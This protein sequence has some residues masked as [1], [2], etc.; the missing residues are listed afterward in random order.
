MLKILCNMILY[1]NWIEY[2]DLEYIACYTCFNPMFVGKSNQL[3]KYDF[4][5]LHNLTSAQ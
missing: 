3:G 1:G 2:R 5:S 4:D